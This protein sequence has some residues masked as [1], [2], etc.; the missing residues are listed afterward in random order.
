M[1]QNKKYE[2]L[3]T[4]VAVCYFRGGE[5]RIARVF[6]PDEK[7]Y[8]KHKD[9]LGFRYECDIEMDA[10]IKVGDMIEARREDMTRLGKFSA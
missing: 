8:M 10:K 1:S 7:G 5:S 4:L 3:E 9:T 2:V 6:V